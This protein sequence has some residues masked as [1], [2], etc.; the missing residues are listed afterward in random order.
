[1][2][3]VANGQLREE[4]L[5]LAATLLV[6]LAQRVVAG[7]ASPTAAPDFEA[8]H[9]LAR[10]AAA[11]GVVLLR[12][13]G[14]VLPLARD[15]RVAVIGE[16]AR[17]PRFQGAGS[18]LINPARLDTALDEITAL[19]DDGTVTFAPG[20]TLDHRDVPAD[21]A[22]LAEA[23]AA[24]SASGTVLFFSASPHGRSPKDLTGSICAFR[25]PSLRRSKRCV[26]RIRTP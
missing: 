6:R 13:E 21:P 7:A 14:G 8:H 19:A 9:A 18:S 20:F 11:R 1:M 25:L 3:A 12:N 5:D 15:V 26:S 22:L 10:E 17:T 23:V 16:F 2:A 4:Q 24:A